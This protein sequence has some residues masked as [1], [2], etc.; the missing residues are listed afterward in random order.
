MD[1]EA[2]QVA[3]DP[4]EGGVIIYDADT[5]KQRLRETENI[6]VVDQS[7]P[8]AYEASRYIDYMQL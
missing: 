5:L 6:K 7:F 8:T 3:Y 4:E 1:Q 2:Y